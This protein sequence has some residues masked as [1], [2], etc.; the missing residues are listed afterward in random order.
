MKTPCLFAAFLSLLIVGCAPKVEEIDLEA[1]RAAILSADKAWSETPPDVASFV[2][3]FAEGAHFLTPDGPL[4][5]GKE[6]IEKI[7]SHLLAP[8]SSL[9]WRATKADVSKAGDLGYSIGTFELTVNDPE[10]NPVTR[11]GKYTTVWRKQADG[12]WKVVADTPN[13]DSPPPLAG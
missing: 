6:D 2:S 12:Q 9:T 13:F 3:F 1:A 10:G 8:G 7:A 11:K 4:A 5:V